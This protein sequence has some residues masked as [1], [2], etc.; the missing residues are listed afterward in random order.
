LWNG[1][2]QAVPSCNTQEDKIERIPTVAWSITSAFDLWE[3]ETVKFGPM[4]SEIDFINKYV[5]LDDSICDALNKQWLLSEY[6]RT[7]TLVDHLTRIRISKE[8]KGN[9]A[10]EFA[11]DFS[12]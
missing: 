2:L 6:S 3:P 4:S 10:Q 9:E 12:K 5:T 11:Q 1:L 8:Y 7:S